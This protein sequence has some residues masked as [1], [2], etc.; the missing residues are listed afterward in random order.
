M[1]EVQ[2]VAASDVPRAVADR[3]LRGHPVRQRLSVAALLLSLHAVASGAA[4]PTGFT[5]TSVATGLQNATAI[6]IAP[7]GRIFVCEQAGALRVVKNGAL[8]P[9]PFG[10]LTVNSIGERGLLGVAFD[11][12]FLNNR[13]VYVYYTATAPTIHNRISRLTANGDVAVPH[14]EVVLLDLPTVNASNHNGG[15]IHFGRDGKLY[16]AVGENAVTANSQTLSNPLGKMLR[17]NSDGTIPSD[18]PFFGSTTGNNR[19]IW[20]LGLR[21][22]FTFGVHQTS[23][24]IFI[25]DVGQNTFEEINDGIAGANYGWPTTEGPTSNPSFV[26]PLHFYGRDSGC[27]IAGGAF[28]APEI[29]Q[30]PSQYVESYFFADL[31]FGWIR[32]LPGAAPPE[33]GFATGISQPV[34]LRVAH[35]GSLYYLARGTGTLVRVRWNGRLAGDVNGDGDTTSADVFYLINHFQGGGPPPAAGRG[36]VNADGL[37]NSADLTYL[38]NYLYARGPTPV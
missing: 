30:F 4:L 33:T 25:N 24:R 21:N 20:A 38:V 28:Y 9:A 34:D 32:R 23:G 27:A 29:R 1:T 36:D 37:V 31:C 35:D 3:L 14:S 26:S 11:P 6:G 7:D 19:A 5:E 15:A 2:G 8:L 12:D 13:F 10:T 18:N 22:P 16:A 17:I